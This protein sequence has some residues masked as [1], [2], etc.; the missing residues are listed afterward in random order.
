MRKTK[1]LVTTLLVPSVIA[2]AVLSGCGGSGSN[3]ATTTAATTKAPAATTAA[4][5]DATTAAEPAGPWELL[6]SL[7]N[8]EGDPLVTPRSSYITYPVDAS[9]ATQT[10]KYWMPLPGNVSKNSPTVNETEWARIWSEQTGIQVE[11]VHPTQGSE[12]EEFG[13]L[14]ASGTLPDIIEWEWTSSYTGGPAAAEKEGVLIILDEYI[15]EY[16]AAADVWQYLQDNPTVN[17]EVKN[18]EGSYYCFPF[19]R[20]DKYLQCTSGPLYRADLLEKAGYTGELVTIDDWTNALTALK[21]YGVEKPLAFQD[22]NYL[23]NFSLNAYEVRNAM[24]VEHGTQTV[25]NGAMEEGYKNWIIQQRA[26]MDA[27][28]L[29]SEVMTKIG[30]ETLNNYMMT[31]TA[32]ATYGAGGGYMGTYLTTAAKDPATYG[33]D[34]NVE[35]A[36]FPVLNKGDVV[37]YGGASYDY[38]TTSKASA[39]ITADCE[40]PE[41]AA[42]FLNWC[43]SEKGHDMINFGEEGVSFNYVDGEP[44]YTDEVMK[45]PNGLTVAV[46]MA[47]WGR[48]NMSGAFVQDPGYITQYYETDQQK[49][50]LAMWNDESD[51]QPSLIPPITMTEE[52][53]KEYSVLNGQVDTYITE[54]RAKFITGEADVEAEWDT[55]VQTLKDLGIERMI[56]LQQAALDRYNAR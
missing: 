23:M 54:M 43:Y 42:K 51:S 3:D 25:K 18:D 7:G 26:W 41:L 19:I 29:D 15:S 53:S 39:S 48:G 46:A 55:Y 49:R 50:A 8:K 13:V 31:G 10:L 52:E 47:H 24:Y 2:T 14:I 4:A 40:N 34:F 12:N 17:R 1:K 38:A 20:G 35:A 21:E 5:G 44:I 36:N 33:E 9:E 56:E 45:N 11:F 6:E 37:K 32:A 16:G 27:G 22:Q 28:L 30:K